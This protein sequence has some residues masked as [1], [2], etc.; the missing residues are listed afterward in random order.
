MDLAMT[1]KDEQTKVKLFLYTIGL[2][3]REIYET[4]PFTEEPADRTLSDV[5]TSFAEHCNP[6]KI[7]DRII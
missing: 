7:R 4:L 6:R 3:G 5:V 1:G 2:K